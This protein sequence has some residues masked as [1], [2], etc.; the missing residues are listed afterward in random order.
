MKVLLALALF[1]LPT[2]G[3]PA[4]GEGCAKFDRDLVSCPS[5]QAP[6]ITELGNGDVVVEFVVSP[7][8][9]VSNARVIAS[10]SR[11]Q[12]DDAVL[13]AVSRWRYKPSTR[14]A[15]KSRHFVFSAHP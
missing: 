3:V 14:S 7:D 9:S 13:P 8:G 12:W 4:D 2:S 10:D 5:V 1:G 15:H 11:H 6:R